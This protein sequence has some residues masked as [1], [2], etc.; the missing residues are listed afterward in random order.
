MRLTWDN[1]DRTVLVNPELGGATI[2]WNLL[3]EAEDELFAAI[4]GTAF[5]TRIILERLEEFGTR[6]DRVINTG[7]IPRKNKLLNQV[8][9]NVLKKPVLVP[10]GDITGLGSAI[11]AFMAIGAFRTIESA[12]KALCVPYRTFE[13]EESTTAVYEE[14]FGH[15]R[16]LYFALGQKDSAPAA[17]GGLLPALRRIT[18]NQNG[19]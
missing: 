18:A 8:Y 6:L 1:G 15:F 16:Q 7:G 9:A 4:E 14:M 3:H 19:S 10:D 2:G 13:P 17:L 11:F 5:H 12:Q